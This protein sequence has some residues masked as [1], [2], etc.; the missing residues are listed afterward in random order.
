MN[1]KLMFLTA[2]AGRLM[3]LLVG[4]LSGFTSVS[5]QEVFDCD[6]LIGTWVGE[7]RYDGDYLEK[8]EAVYF[9]DGRFSIEFFDEADTFVSNGE[10]T[11]TCDG[12]WVV[13]TTVEGGQEYSFSYQIR[14]LNSF[15]YDYESSQG[16]VFTSF[17]KRD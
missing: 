11:W 17:R 7:H 2:S 14:G 9:E 12:V 3:A 1:N 6:Q 13:S 10:G 5:A 4:L 15:R 8:W 16:P